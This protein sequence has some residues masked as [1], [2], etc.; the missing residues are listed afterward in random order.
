VVFGV[1]IELWAVRG[2][3]A[4]LALRV[5]AGP[6]TL[7]VLIGPLALWVSIGL[8]AFWEAYVL[9]ILAFTTPAKPVAG[10]S[11]LCGEANASY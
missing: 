3:Q 2:G 6:L 9:A 5:L 11:L 7:W 4:F 10:G 8:W 1:S